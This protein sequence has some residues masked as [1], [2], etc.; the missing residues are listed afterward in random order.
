MDDIPSGGLQ[1]PRGVED[2]HHLKRGDP[3]HALREI[4][5]Y[6]HR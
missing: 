6:R 5:T 1:A 4:G 3:S 2:L